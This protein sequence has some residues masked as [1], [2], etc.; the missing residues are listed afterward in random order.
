M[1]LLKTIGRGILAGIITCALIGLG[2]AVALFS[3]ILSVLFTIALIFTCVW[4]VLRWM[5][6]R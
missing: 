1:G 4:F 5:A 2:L 6:D 3:S